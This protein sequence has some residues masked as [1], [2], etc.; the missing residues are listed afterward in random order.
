[1]AWGMHEGPACGGDGELGEGINGMLPLWS[2]PHC[3]CKVGTLLSAAHPLIA[4]ALY[5]EVRL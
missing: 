3:W 1:M 2:N 4:L 5:P